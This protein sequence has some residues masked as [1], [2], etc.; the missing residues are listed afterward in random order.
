M[1]NKIKTYC[2]QK[3]LLQQGDRVLLGISGGADSVCL[4]FVLLSLAG[5]SVL[6]AKRMF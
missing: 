4:L 5:E 3:E 6:S 1:L 2:R